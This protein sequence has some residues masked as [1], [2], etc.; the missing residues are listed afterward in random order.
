MWSYLQGA[1]I[2]A[3]L[4]IAIGAQNSFVLAQGIKRQHPFKIAATCSLCDIILILIGTT[5]IGTLL[6]NSPQLIKIATWGG[7]LFL[8]CYGLRACCSAIKGKKELDQG[9]QP[10]SGQKTLL[11]T[12]A[13]S[14][15]NPH[16]YLDTCVLLG[17]LGSRFPTTERYLFAAGAASASLLWF[18][19]LSFG[20]ALL[21]PL[22][23]QSFAWRVLDGG[24][25]LVMWGIALTLLRGS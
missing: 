20:A 15:L 12:L 3:G 5:S 4:I 18:F 17:T 14:L 24:I 13:L 19:S 21:A 2:G 1:G 23:R 9:S 10:P 11:T 8:A 7:A 6:A 22:F 16:V 25:A